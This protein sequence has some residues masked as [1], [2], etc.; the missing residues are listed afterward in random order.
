MHSA[1]CGMQIG[2]SKP[3][4]LRPAKLAARSPSA[5]DVQDVLAVLVLHMPEFGLLVHSV[6]ILM[7]SQLVFHSATQGNVLSER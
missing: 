3:H 6:F 7:V 4:R 2:P 1:L 5:N